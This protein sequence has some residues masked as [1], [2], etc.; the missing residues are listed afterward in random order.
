VPTNRAH[1]DRQ[2]S[3]CAAMALVPLDDDHILGEQQDITDLPRERRRPSLSGNPKRMNNTL[4]RGVVHSEPTLQ[5]VEVG[6][7]SFATEK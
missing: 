6:L 7:R 5:R 1:V 3:H 2:L 4:S